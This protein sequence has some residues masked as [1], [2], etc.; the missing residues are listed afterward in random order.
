MKLK[1]LAVG[2]RM[3][4]WVTQG[5]EEYRKRLPRE[6]SL[7]VVELSPGPRQKSADPAKAIR[8][9]GDRLLSRIKDSE[10]VVA[11]DVEGKPWSTPVLSERMR[12]WQMAGS[13]VSLL[14]G[15]PDGLDQ[16]CLA[17]ADLRWSLSPLTLPHPLVRVLLAEQ[18]YR[19]WTLMT[20]HPYHR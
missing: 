15:G 14:I 12:D 17:R 4:G 18:L 6:M 7:E 2:T 1:M 3:P 9:E 16:R 8:V 11:L 20:G 19:G 13:D 10:L 5:V